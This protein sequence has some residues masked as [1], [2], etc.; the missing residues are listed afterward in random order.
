MD[1]FF[2]ETV[3]PTQLITGEDAHHIAKA[4]RKSVGELLTLC[5]KNKTQHLCRIEKIS[6]EGVLVRVVSANECLHEPS[7]EITLMAALTKGDKMENVIQK[8]VELGVHKIVPVLTARCIS[9]PDAKAAEKKQQRY[10]K[11]AEQA[12][13][14][15][16]R[17]I[18]PTVT[19]F[20][21]LKTAALT[22]SSFDKSILFYE[23]G[24]APLRNIIDE[25]CRSL[26]IFTGPEGGF[27]ESEV[28]LLADH[29]DSLATL[30]PR[31]LR[32][33]TAPLA[34]LAAILLHTHN[35]E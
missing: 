26:A 23:G 31:I 15:S 35:L 16:Q 6:P 3:A 18:I 5:D 27:E 30:G 2:V 17:G 22:L 24:G 12:A 20:T 10:Q 28:Q 1:W 8:S 25:N 9:R 34:A 32:A 21:D 29:G 11:I 19:A 14:Q 4:L 7:V 13:M 33:E